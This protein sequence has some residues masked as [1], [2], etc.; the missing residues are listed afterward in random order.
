MVPPAM[1]APSFPD[2]RAFL[3]QLRRD[4]DLAVVDGTG[5]PLLDR[6]RIRLYWLKKNSRFC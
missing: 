6:Y 1:T 3:D 2:L 5:G 4:G